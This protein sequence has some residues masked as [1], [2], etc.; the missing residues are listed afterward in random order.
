MTMG[1]AGPTGQFEFWLTRFRP[2]WE[3]DSIAYTWPDFLLDA[4]IVTVWK[5]VDPCRLN[6]RVEGVGAQPIDLVAPCVDLV[7]APA[8]V[9]GVHVQLKWDGGRITLSLNGKTAADVSM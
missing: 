2:G 5:D 1:H 6:F 8:G 9:R 7:D 4:H 3:A